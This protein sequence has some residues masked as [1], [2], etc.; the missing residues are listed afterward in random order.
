M[1]DVKKFHLAQ[2][3][4][5]ARSAS[6]VATVRR[7]TQTAYEAGRLARDELV[8][9]Q[10]YV[11]KTGG[12]D[13]AKIKPLQDAINQLIDA[14]LATDDYL[15]AL[16]PPPRIVHLP[17]AD[18]DRFAGRSLDEFDELTESLV[19]RL[20]EVGIKTIGDLENA[21]F[22]ELAKQR[23]LHPQQMMCVKKFLSLLG[24]DGGPVTTR[25]TG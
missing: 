2:D 5:E 6:T 7:A 3:E 24:R 18:S 10:A 19:N 12:G 1:D 11:V 23:V 4:A 20:V 16:E 25:R 15:Y 14:A 13:P 8:H 9:Y 22:R 17:P 21:N